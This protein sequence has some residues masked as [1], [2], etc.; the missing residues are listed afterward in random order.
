[1]LCLKSEVRGLRCEL[2]LSGL[3]SEVAGL[4]FQVCG[5]RFEV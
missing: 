2:E 1:M 5:V 4:M 3:R